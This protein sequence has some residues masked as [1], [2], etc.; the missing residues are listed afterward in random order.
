MPA[1]NRLPDGP[2]CRVLVEDDRTIAANLVG[3]LSAGGR[4]LDV[5]YD[6]RAALARLES[7]TFDVVLP[8][9]EHRAQSSFDKASTPIRCSQRYYAR[10]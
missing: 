4:C 2:P 6:G 9:P 1:S 5:A 10:P 7:E 3:F 8:A